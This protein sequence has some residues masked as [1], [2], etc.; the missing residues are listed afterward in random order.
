MS[1]FLC[2][3][4][5]QTLPQMDDALHEEVENIPVV[6][7]LLDYCNNINGRDCTAAELQ[8]VLNS[9][10]TLDYLKEMEQPFLHD[11]IQSKQQKNY[12][13]RFRN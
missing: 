3:R 1:N 13:H 10:A 11:V 2:Y 9:D 7:S 12:I 4:L 6:S 5:L 8:R